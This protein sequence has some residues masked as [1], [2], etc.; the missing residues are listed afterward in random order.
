MANAE[1]DRQAMP[2]R[3]NSA[4]LPVMENLLAAILPGNHVIVPCPFAARGIAVA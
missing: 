3:I 4:P 1:R 2:D